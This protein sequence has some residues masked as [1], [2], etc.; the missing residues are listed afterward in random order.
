MYQSSVLMLCESYVLL[1]IFPFLFYIFIK[2][3]KYMSLIHF[4]VKIKSNTILK[5][6]DWLY[7][8]SHPQP[9]AH[10]YISVDNISFRPYSDIKVP[11][12]IS[13]AP[14]ETVYSAA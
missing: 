2:K 4:S 8:K 5:V 7:V 3:Q 13:N 9:V 6:K 10:E 12:A 14:E 11:V 1:L